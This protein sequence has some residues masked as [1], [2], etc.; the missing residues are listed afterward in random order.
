MTAVDNLWFLA[1]EAA[2]QAE[3][4]YHDLASDHDDYLEVTLDRRVSRN[5]FRT[6][7]RRIRDNGLPYGAHTVTYRSGGELLLV[8]HE[9]VDLWVLP[10]GEVDEGETF[11]EC[12]RRELAEETGVEARFSGVGILARVEFYTADHDTWGVLPIYEA[13]A[14]TTDLTVADPDG[15]I[16][17]AAWFA[18]LPPD[19]RDRAELRRWRERRFDD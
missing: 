4:T 5:R 15:E 9:D 1:D 18:D 11:R 3:R 16:S 6:V 13:R 8:R 7:A 14:E 12:A 19:T 2:R 10:G 17:D